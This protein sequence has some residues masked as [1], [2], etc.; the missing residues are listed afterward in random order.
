MYATLIAPQPNATPG[1][2]INNSDDDADDDNENGSGGG[3]KIVVDDDGK[4]T[5]VLDARGGGVGQCHLKPD[6]AFFA[7]GEVC[8]LL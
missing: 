8:L 1:R 7:D 5:F 2:F 4:R 6:L 3:V